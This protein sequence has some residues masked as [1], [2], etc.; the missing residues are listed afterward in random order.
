VIHRS[1]DTAEDVRTWFGQLNETFAAVASGAS[2]MDALVANYAVPVF[3]T[4]DTEHVVLEDPEAIAA[5]MGSV[6]SALRNEGYVTTEMEREEIS[7][8]NE[9][10]A[11]IDVDVVRMRGD[12]S[13]IAGLSAVEIAVRSDEEW[14]ISAVMV[15]TTLP[16]T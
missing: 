15:R 6:I 12:R 2:Q 8:I 9:R 13:L 11:I 3:L 5:Y 16:T 10:A 7:I 4:T 1:D 14:R